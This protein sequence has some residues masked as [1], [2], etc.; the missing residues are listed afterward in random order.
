[1]AVKKHATAQQPSHQDDLTTLIKYLKDIVASPEYSPP[2]EDL[3]KKCEDLVICLSNTTG[4]VSSFAKLLAVIEGLFLRLNALQAG[5]I[6]RH[7][8]WPIVKTYSALISNP[9]NIFSDATPYAL[10]VLQSEDDLGMLTLAQAA[11]QENDDGPADAKNRAT[12]TCMFRWVL[13]NNSFPV[14]VA[15]LLAYMKALQ[16]ADKYQILI[17]V[18][19]EN[20]GSLFILMGS[21][22]RAEIPPL[23]CHVLSCLRE[24]LAALHSIS[25]SVDQVLMALAD[26]N[27]PLL[28]IIVDII[29]AMIDYQTSTLKGRCLMAF[30]T[31]YSDLISCL[32]RHMASS[33]CEF[34]NLQPWRSMANL[35][36]NAEANTP[37]LVNLG[38]TCYMNSVMQALLVTRQLSNHA[39]LRMMRAPYW[40]KMGE[41][42][43]RMQHS[44]L[45][46]VTPRDFF[47]ATCPPFFVYDQQ[48]DSSEFLGYLLELLKTYERIT[49]SNHDYTRPPVL[50]GYRGRALAHVAHSSSDEHGEGSTNRRAPS[51][52]PGSSASGVAK[53]TTSTDEGPSK[54]R[55]R[56]T[57]LLRDS[58]IDR[59]FAGVLI[60]RVE[61]TVCHS[62]S[63]SRDVFRDLQLAFPEKAE[64][65][66]YSVQNLLEFYC[67]TEYL[68]GENKYS[69]RDCGALR[70]AERSVLIEA[71]PKYLIIVLKNFKFEPK[72]QVQTKLMHTVYHNHDIVVPTTRQSKGHVSY[73]LY[74]AVIHSGTTLDSGHYYT[75]AKHNDKW[76]IFN[77]HVVTDAKSTML[78]SLARSHTPYIL[79]YKRTD[80]EE[81]PAPALTDLSQRL[82]DSINLHDKEFGGNGAFSG[83]P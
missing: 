66:E 34:L 71:T 58:I 11:M 7:I 3:I 74:A 22:P 18:C 79:F 14:L 80:T 52:R 55:F 48:H 78:H 35:S 63:I 45:R 83:R 49:D 25:T 38:N 65:L 54:K 53:R 28:Q 77:D 82:K 29:T 70:D 23:V 33:D 76:K 59:L 75:Y 69:C 15:W 43:A 50:L 24:S 73:N 10:A 68:T 8:T 6:H 47:L 26:D 51:P 42:F 9:Q 61:C 1:M 46:S 5:S 64:P 4:N 56:S 13:S 19:I 62:A 20:L 41:L 27:R 81:L 36:Q 40:E 2:I 16:E 72:L 12:L 31:N 57:D 37:G 32:E 17:E 39:I 67:S 30:R 44:S 21:N 60:T